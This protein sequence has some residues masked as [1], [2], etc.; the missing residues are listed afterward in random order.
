MAIVYRTI[1][2]HELDKGLVAAWRGIAQRHETFESPY[3]CPEFTQLVGEV[4]SD[5]RVTLI[6]DGGIPVG[7]FPHQRAAW[8]SGRPVGGPLSDYHG[9]IASPEVEWDPRDLMRAARLAVWS[10]DHLVGG[11]GKMRPYV[12]TSAISPKIDLGAGYAEYAQ[13]RRASGSEYIGKTEALGRK[14]GRDV[15]G[16]GFALHEAGAGSLERMIDWKRSQYREAGIQDVFGVP[17][18]GD[19]LRRILAFQSPGFS[20]MCSV[21]RVGD[22]VVAVHVGMRSDRVLHYWFPAYDP[23]FRKYS[24]GILLLLRMAEFVGREGVRAIDLGK[25]ESQYKSR[26]MN[27]AV[28]L[29][30]GCVVRPSMMA[31]ARRWR[32]WAENRAARGGVGAPLRIPLRAL[33]RLERRRK[34]R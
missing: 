17:W 3:F 33:R 27:G 13:E 32:E 5:V 16:L 31:T 21:L 10:F 4:R 12:R 9:V 11:D 8:G 20:G 25:G 18:T 6:D 34:F 1:G 29:G 26:L 24:P 23:A 30:E 22:E 14:L 28:E 19:L 15:G 2:A 7:F